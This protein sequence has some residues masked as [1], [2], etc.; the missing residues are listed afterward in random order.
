MAIVKGETVEEFHQ[1]FTTVDDLWALRSK[2]F[3]NSDI[4]DKADNDQGKAPNYDPLI[5]DIRKGLRKSSYYSNPLM[6]CDL[7]SITGQKLNPDLEKLYRNGV[8]AR[9]SNIRQLIRY[10]DIGE[11]YNAK[12]KITILNDQN[13][14]STNLFDK[15]IQRE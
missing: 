11:A 6:P 4:K 12:N 8:N 10:N 2:I 5:F 7:K 13:N 1:A 14:A 9:D 3:E 15:Y